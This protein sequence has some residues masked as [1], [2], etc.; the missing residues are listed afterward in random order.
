M[1]SKGDR[2]F[3][4]RAVRIKNGATNIP[5]PVARK[6]SFK[7]NMVSAKL[8]GDDII[9]DTVTKPD[10]YELSLESGGIPY[11]ALSLM[12]GATLT[13]PT[14]TSQKIQFKSTDVYPYFELYGQA[15]G[16]GSDGALIHFTKCKIKDYNGAMNQK[17]FYINTMTVD[18][19]A[20]DNG[21][22]YEILGDEAS[23][24]TTPPTT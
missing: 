4:L 13:N 19:L 11:A 22:F 24:N 8:E 17:E 2:P 9:A 1:A 3:G 10:S 7:P 15:I 16:T 14:S 5:L 20:D 21:V 23:G 12:L 18:A 6:V